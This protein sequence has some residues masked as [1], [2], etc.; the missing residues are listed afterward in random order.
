MA[1][2]AVRINTAIGFGT[3]VVRT[4][5][6]DGVL[7][8]MVP[9]MLRGGTGFVLAIDASCSQAELQG[10]KNQE[11]DCEPATHCGGSVAATGF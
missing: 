2:A 7:M 4:L 11:E 5:G 9:E 8:L 6:I 3:A 10:Q 1:G